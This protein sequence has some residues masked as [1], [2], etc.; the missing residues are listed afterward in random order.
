MIL[1]LKYVQF[2]FNLK[3]SRTIE[4]KGFWSIILFLSMILSLL[5]TSYVQIK[6]ENDDQSDEKSF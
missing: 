6:L 3:I 2:I 4:R 5:I 1:N